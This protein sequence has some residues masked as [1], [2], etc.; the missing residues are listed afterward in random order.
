VKSD[1]CALR[2][3]LPCAKVENLLEQIRNRCFINGEVSTRV[4]SGVHLCEPTARDYRS[5]PSA[6]NLTGA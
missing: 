5:E 6:A 1:Y 2:K 4:E 3:N